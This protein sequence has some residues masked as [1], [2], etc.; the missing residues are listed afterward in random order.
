MWLYSFIS[1]YFNIIWKCKIKHCAHTIQRFT[2]N[3]GCTTDF[4]WN[5][6]P[7]I[8]FFPLS[9]WKDW[10]R[11]AQRRAIFFWIWWFQNSIP[12]YQIV[13]SFCV[14]AC[15]RA[16]MYDQFFD[17]SAS[18]SFMPCLTLFR[19]LCLNS[20]VNVQYSAAACYSS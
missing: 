7:G 15:V 8:G 16:S 13:F 20:F 5:K 11:H 6:V 17:V 9:R 3:E 1:F 19:F 18:V 2:V 4:F 12:W 10:D 14:R